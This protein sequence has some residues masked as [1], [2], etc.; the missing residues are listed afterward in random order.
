MPATD[1]ATPEHLR[2]RDAAELP[3]PTAVL[4]TRAHR[5]DSNSIFVPRSLAEAVERLGELAGDATLAIVTEAQLRSAL[6]EAATGVS[7]GWAMVWP[8]FKGRRSG[9]AK[10]RFR[11]PSGHRPSSGK[12]SCPE[13]RRVGRQLD[14]C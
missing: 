9:I 13:T 1:T 5:S 3:A 7:S 6:D 12:S 11:G 4:H 14:G 2:V 8:K 10:Q